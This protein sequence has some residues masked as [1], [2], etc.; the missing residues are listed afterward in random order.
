MPPSDDEDAIVCPN[1]HLSKSEL[2][3]AAGA[4]VGAWS[5]T[6]ET[7]DASTTAPV[8]VALRGV[9]FNPVPGSQELVSST[10][11]VGIALHM[12]QFN[13]IPGTQE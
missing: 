9:R 4:A 12:T 11:A 8:G 13:P 5:R 3:R 6:C 2:T 10:N 7:I 1:Q